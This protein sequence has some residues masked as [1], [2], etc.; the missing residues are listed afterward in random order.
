GVNQAGF[1]VLVGAS[2]PNVLFET[3]FLSNVN[4]E[5]TLSTE[6]GQQTM[7]E[8]IVKAIK[9]YANEYAKNN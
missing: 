5:K 6:R 2:M 3:G 7:A 1:L 9:R 4:D 8:G